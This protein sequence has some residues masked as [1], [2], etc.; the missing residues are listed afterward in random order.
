MKKLSL[1]IIILMSACSV[2]AQ[3]GTREIHGEVYNL[4]TREPID[5]ATVRNIS[6]NTGAVTNRAG[7]FTI[8]ARPGDSIIVH[9]LSFN[10][11]TLIVG[12]KTDYVIFLRLHENLLE[13]VKIRQQK[14]VPID[15]P[16]DPF[17][18]KTVT[19]KIDYFSKEANSAD[20]SRREIGGLNVRI[21]TNKKQEKKRAQI[22]SLALE[23]QHELELRK[24][25]TEENIQKYLPIRGQDLK[26]FMILYRP[27]MSTTDLSEYDIVLYLNDSYKKF[28]KLSAKE[29]QEVLLP[30]K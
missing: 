21:F 28:E 24:V 22:E 26:T 5:M 18:G 15:L 29:K 25:F 19:N 14:A 10:G 16:K 13:E 23:K 30:A 8:K 9:N 2:F 4:D 6:L 17:D 27:D 11:D 7:A 1:L 20:R 12:S 3:H